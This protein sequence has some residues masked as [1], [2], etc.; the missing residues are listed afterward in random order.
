MKRQILFFVTCLFLSTSCT[1]ERPVPQKGNQVVCKCV[2]VSDGDTITV[3]TKNKK[4]YKVRLAHIDCPEKG[5]PFGKNAKQFTSDFCFN[6]MV[7]VLHDG[8]KDRNGRVIGMVINDGGE[9]LNKALVQAGMAWHFAKYSNDPSYAQL[10][11]E[12]RAARV[13][14]WQEDGAVAPWMWR[15]G[16]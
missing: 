16:R 11:A 1:N 8:K 4:Q 14:L 10:E 5:Q 7:T 6:Q 15:K 2:G 13:G 12:A 3:L 9:N